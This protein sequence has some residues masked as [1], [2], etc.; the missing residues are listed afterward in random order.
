M[1]N[2]AGFAAQSEVSKEMAQRLAASLWDEELWRKVA[3]DREVISA[4]EWLETVKQAQE[5]AEQGA[6]FEWYR[7]VK[8][9]GKGSFGVVDLVKGKDN[10]LYVMKIVLRTGPKTSASGQVREAVNEANMLKTLNHPN[11]VEF[12]EAFNEGGHICIVMAYCESGDLKQRI[13]KA[14]KSNKNFKQALVMDWFV[15]MA[16][17]LH[18]LHAQHIMHRD[19]K[20]Q[21]IFLTKNNR[22]VKIGD[23]G[24]TQRLD[25]TLEEALTTVGTPYYMSPELAT[26]APYTQKSDV[27][28][29]GCILS[30]VCSTEVPFPAKS[31]PELVQK[32]TGSEPTP[33]PDSYSPEVSRIINW[34]LIKDREQR[35]LMRELMQ[36]PFIIGSIR[37]Y[38][39]R[40]GDILKE[41]PKSSS[42]IEKLRHDLDKAQRKRLKLKDS[43]E[44]IGTHNPD[45]NP[46]TPEQKKKLKAAERHLRNQLADVQVQIYIMEKQLDDTES[47]DTKEIV[48]QFETTLGQDQ[49]LIS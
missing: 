37:D 17:G 21:N 3:G 15:Q 31:F 25:G 4:A 33:I 34:M 44:Q 30:E 9:I 24:V 29:L 26:N 32:I 43:L 41:G 6:H 49:S 35:P 20:P 46:L 47:N 11:I 5:N 10:K 27:W 16:Q 12:K 18:Y 1:G 8:R 39:E 14:K 23:F 7:K 36:D 45:S 28:A 19:L 38:K 48:H 42:E 13:K 40:L 22:I 2:A